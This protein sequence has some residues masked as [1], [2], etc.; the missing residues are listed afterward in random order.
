M[1]TFYGELVAIKEEIGGYII[2]VFKNLDI[3]FEYEMCTRLPNWSGSII[4]IG[5]KGYVS[6]KNVE[7]GKHTWYNI[8]QQT[9]ILY[10]YDGN[11]FVNFIKDKQ[12]EDKLTI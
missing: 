2:Y 6:I 11:Y 10:K 12:Q 8:H 5:D 4:K 3:K 9:Q 1:Y 7:G